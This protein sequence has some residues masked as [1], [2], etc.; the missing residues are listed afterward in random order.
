MILHHI[1]ATPQDYSRWITCQVDP[2]QR[3]KGGFKFVCWKAI[4]TLTP[5]C[6]AF[7]V[8][9]FGFM[10]QFASRWLADKALVNDC[11]I[12][13]EL[14]KGWYNKIDQFIIVPTTLFDYLTLST[15]FIA[16]GLVK[17]LLFSTIS[18]EWLLLQQGKMQFSHK[19]TDKPFGQVE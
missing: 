11:Y 18:R 3:F 13:C 5:F 10:N 12:Q 2:R 9:Q 4:G 16:M 7:L 14:R 1:W 17:P 15:C 19:T 6:T 8:A